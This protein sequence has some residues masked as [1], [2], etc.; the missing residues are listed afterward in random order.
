MSADN[1]RPK[2]RTTRKAARAAAGT[3]PDHGR[4]RV[5]LQFTAPGRPSV[6]GSGAVVGSSLL[7]AGLAGGHLR[8][9]LLWSGRWWR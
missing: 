8:R 4:G 5:V 9:S 6:S 2:R 3:H 7:A 1:N